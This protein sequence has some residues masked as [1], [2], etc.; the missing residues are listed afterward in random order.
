MR[1]RHLVTLGAALGLLAGAGAP[2][3]AQS[4]YGPGGLFLH[5]TASV[6]PMGKLTP[7][8][9]VLP[10]HNP[11]VD[12]TRTWLTASVDYGLLPDLEIGATYLKVAGWDKDAS[13]GGFAKWRFQREGLV[14]PALAAGFTY[15]GG[16][17]V[18]TRV[19]FLAASKGFGAGKLA[20]VRGH[21]GLQY[22]DRVDGI[23]K[24]D[25]LPYAGIEL[26]LTTRLAVTAEAR[27]RGT[28]EF[29]TP[30]A[31]TLQYRP[32]EDVTLAFTWANNGMSDRPMLGFGAGWSLGTRR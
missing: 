2:A 13:L 18:D 21:L 7:S 4:L 10:Q 1:T 9:I 17:D 20:S 15:L 32:N 14:K 29:G 19:A 26:G 12:S 16:G 11:A 28:G 22:A 30:L 6:P 5:P 25:L 8:I 31:L 23:R 24:N 3:S 27:P